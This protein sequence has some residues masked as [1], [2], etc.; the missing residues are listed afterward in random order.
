MRFQRL[1]SAT[2]S[3]MLLVVIFGSIHAGQAQSS[4]VVTFPTE[5][6]LTLTG[7]LHLPAK[8]GPF[9]GVVMVAEPT[10][11]LRSTFDTSNLAKD[12]AKKYGM[13]GLTVDLRGTGASLNG[14]HFKSY[15]PQELDKVQLDIRGAI[16]FLISQNVDPHRIGLVAVGQGANYAVLEAADNAAVQGVV[17]L[18]GELSQK[19]R[20]LIRTRSDIPVFCIAGK[21]DKESFREMSEAF[22]SSKNKA[23]DILLTVGHGTVMFSHTAGMADKVEQWLA[24]NV[25]DLGTEA[26][27]SLTSS[28]GWNLHGRL[29]LPDGANES[30]KVPG[31]VMVHGAM[32]DQ[33]TY[34]DLARG[35]VKKGMA[36]LTFD[37]RGKNRDVNEG[38]GDYGVNLAKGEENKIYLDIKAAI[39]F[40]ASQKA[41][42]T[43]RMG[44]VAATMPT[45]QAMQASMGDSRIKTIVILTQYILSPEAKQFLTSSDVPVFFIA[46]SEDLNTEVGSLADSTHEAYRLSKSKGSQLLLYD[47][48]GRGSEML[49]EKDELQPMIVRWLSEKLSKQ[50]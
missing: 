34:Y 7:T 21:D 49:K 23:S 47:D 31:V 25:R 14:R 22:Y 6:G 15:S 20:D 41:I 26:A 3:V 38:K 13:A 32:H 16:Q 10:W 1:R 11:I 42:D 18:S 28:D 9:A 5:D 4:K 27:I 8:A 40:L 33:E 44:V 24:G 46:S 45:N 30:S 37:W 50:P 48:A 19:A 29:F 43:T 35:V 39:Q 12:L 2:I 17:L 36:A